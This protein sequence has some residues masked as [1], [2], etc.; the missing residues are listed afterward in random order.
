MRQRGYRVYGPYQQGSSFRVVITRDDGK[1]RSR[2]FRA[3]AEADRYADT[4]RSDTTGVTMKSAVE[5][6]VQHLVDRGLKFGTYDRAE[7]HLERLLQLETSGRR[8]I[9]WIARRGQELYDAAQVGAAVDSH[10]N[11]LAAG[12][13]WGRFCVKRGWLRSDPF[14]E[15]DGMGRRKKGK[16]QLRVDEARKLTDYLLAACSPAPR[17]EPAAV[18]AVLLLGTR[19]SELVERDVRDLDDDGQL[20]WIPDSKTES[21]KRTLEVPSLLRPLLLA[22]AKDRI[23]AAPLL[24]DE[25]GERPTRFWMG[26]WCR[27]YCKLAGV[28][29]ITPQGFRGT[30]GSIARRGGA[31]GHIV[32]EQLGHASV[33]MTEG[34]AYVQRSAIDAATSRAVELKLFAGGKKPGKTEPARKRRAG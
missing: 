25:D 10:R 14:A 11:A 17:Y 28:P 26:Y 2:K 34:G 7:D 20:L 1:T 33:A 18:L 30:H 31:T 12:K 23:G 8:P 21:G 16:P 32:Q 15:V 4:Y 19:A 5:A 13:S 22:L 6:Y 27:R 29:D 3:R 9:S 24:L